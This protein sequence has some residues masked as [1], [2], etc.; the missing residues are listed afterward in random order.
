MIKKL[1]KTEQIK[2]M[3]NESNMHKVS[4][5]NKYKLID[6]KTIRTPFLYTKLKKDSNFFKMKILHKITNISLKL[7]R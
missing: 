3:C 5:H 4:E 7:Q 1:I 2:R 6:V